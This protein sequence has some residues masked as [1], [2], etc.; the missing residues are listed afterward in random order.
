MLKFI[1][2]KS[3]QFRVIQVFTEIDIGIRIT[4]WSPSSLDF[5]SISIKFIFWSFVLIKD[6]R[7]K[8]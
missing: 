2:I 1:D 8:K 6:F 7:G 5:F 3:F 4:G